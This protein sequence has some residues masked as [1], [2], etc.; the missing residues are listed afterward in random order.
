MR[1]NVVSVLLLGSMLFPVAAVASQTK[2][3]ASLTTPNLRVSTGVV[4][5]SIVETAAIAVPQGMISDAVPAG[6]QVGLSLTVDQ[7]GVPQN[8]QVVRSLNQAWD[9][10]V[11]DAVRQFRFRPGTIDRK[12]IPVDVNLT[13]NI[14]R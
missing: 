14:T 9:A 12:P 2:T 6:A 1:R 5:P 10:S 13:V 11:V 3:D 4:A 7:N 8:I